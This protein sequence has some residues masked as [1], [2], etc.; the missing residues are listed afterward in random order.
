MY[1][2]EHKTVKTF[3]DRRAWEM[4]IEMAG[5][6]IRPVGSFG[7][8]ESIGILHEKMR[9]YSEKVFLQKFILP[10][11]R[12]KDL[13]CVNICSLVA[14]R[15]RRKTVLLGTHFD[16]RWIADREKDPALKTMPIPGVNDG[17]SGVAVILELM[18]AFQQSPPSF[19]VLCVLFDAEDVGFID[20]FR[21]GEGAY[22]FVDHLVMKLDLAIIIDMIA[23]RGMRINLDNNSLLSEVSTRT[24]NRIFDIG[25]KKGYPAFF[26]NHSIELESDHTPFYQRNIPALILMDI[27]YPEWHTHRDTLESCCQKSLRYVGDVLFEFFTR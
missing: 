1:L 26:N 5:R 10:H 7:H 11:F 14:G 12:G 21:F 22:H 17:T 13:E 2:R 25:R 4:M 19:N 9:Q 24:I 18:R 6:G 3:D 27:F 15:D 8:R 20:G 16:T 23:G